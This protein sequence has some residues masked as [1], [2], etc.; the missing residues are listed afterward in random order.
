MYK[1]LMYNIKNNKIVINNSFLPLFTADLTSTEL[2]MIIREISTINRDDL[3][4][5]TNKWTVEETVD[6]FGL[7]KKSKN[8]YKLIKEIIN[9]LSHKK[10]NFYT[11]DKKL[12]SSIY[13][14]EKAEYNDGRFIIK[15]NQEIF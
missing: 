4:F 12:Y 2:K 3:N 11:D 5:K 15:L 1:T 10:I 9:S 7:S 14:L 6:D 8:N 13:L